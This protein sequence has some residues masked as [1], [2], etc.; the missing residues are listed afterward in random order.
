MKKNPNSKIEIT[1]DTIQDDI[2]MKR[3]DMSQKKHTIL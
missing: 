2:G 3:K 1:Y